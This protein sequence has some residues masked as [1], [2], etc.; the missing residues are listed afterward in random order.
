M[1]LDKWSGLTAKWMTD[2]KLWEVPKGLNALIDMCSHSPL[3]LDW[4]ICTPSLVPTDDDLLMMTFSNTLMQTSH[5]L[6][7]G[8]LLF[9]IMLLFLHFLMKSIRK[10]IIHCSRTL[11]L[12][13]LVTFNN[14]WYSTWICSGILSQQR[15]GSICSMHTFMKPILL[16]KT[17]N[18]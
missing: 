10:L 13:N 3:D 8:L 11:F 18:H 16:N 17:G 5:H 2:P 12:M 7:F 9:W 14:K 1:L 4:F 6:T 15:Q